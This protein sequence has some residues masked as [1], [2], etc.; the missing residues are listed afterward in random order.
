MAFELLDSY[1]L[2][3]NEIDQL[4]YQRIQE[5]FLLRRV[6]SEAH[7]LQVQKEQFRRSHQTSGRG[8]TRRTREV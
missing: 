1:H 6:K 2:N 4:S 3:P 5:I 8:G 7:N